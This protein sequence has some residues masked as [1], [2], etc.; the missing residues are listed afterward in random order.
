MIE[1]TMNIS[2][3]AAARKAPSWL[4]PVLAVAL[5][6]AVI[7]GLGVTVFRG[8]L[9]DLGLPQQ[10]R[11]S[12]QEQFFAWQRGAAYADLAVEVRALAELADGEAAAPLR[13]LDESLSH[14]A[15]LL[16]EV[17]SADQPGPQLSTDYSPE[18]AE[19]VAERVLS[20]GADVGL[21]RVEDQGLS[22]LL[23][24]AAFEAS[25]DARTLLSTVASD[26]AVDTSAMPLSGEALPLAD[27]QENAPA[28]VGCLSDP[29][30][31]SPDAELPPDA[32]AAAAH[33]ARALDR[34]YALDYVL[35][36]QAARG[37]SQAAP[38]IEGQRDE[39]NN[40]LD[41]L[42]T[43]VNGDCAD[44]R[45]PAYELPEGS[46]ENLADVATELETD[47][48]NELLLAVSAATGEGQ[49]ALATAAWQHLT[50][51]QDAGE[52]VQLLGLK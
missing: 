10:I 29:A 17:R 24:R 18:A 19:Q 11:G 28:L 12:S 33:T 37:S 47:F 48:A 7:W 44:L 39:L 41:Q 3:S 38:T 4:A 45:L 46:M 25:L 16:G 35:Q 15:A 51:R 40:Q 50:G 26:A 2:T 49:Q 22:A 13:A 36:L 31:L 5:V 30:L 23:V 6:L 9:E 8:T 32:D 34:G 20:M 42:L 21:E 43:A 27:G 1:T 52:E 14:A